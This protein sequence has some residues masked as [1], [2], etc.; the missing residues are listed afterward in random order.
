MLCNVAK[1]NAMQEM[2]CMHC[3]RTVHVYCMEID[4]PSIEET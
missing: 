4:G 3:L 2:H 1:V